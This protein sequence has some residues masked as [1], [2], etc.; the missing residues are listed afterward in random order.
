MGVH[1]KNKISCNGGFTLIELLVVVLIIGILAS[2][3]LPQYQKAVEKSRASEAVT[4]LKSLRDQQELCFLEQGEVVS[5]MQGD[6][7]DNLFTNATITIPGGVEEGCQDEICGASTKDFTYSL[8][9]DGIYAN[10]KPY[11]TKYYLET[12]AVAG[13]NYSNRILCYNEGSENWCSKAGFTKKEG[14]YYIKP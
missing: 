3:A 8:S 12:T 1:M 10:R 9:G 13:R 14:N 4:I 5:C 7:N 2:I 6:E 11:G